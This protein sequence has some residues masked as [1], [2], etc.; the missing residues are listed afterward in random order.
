MQS[1]DGDA[2][3]SLAA[4]KET[5]VRKAIKRMKSH[6]PALTPIIVRI[7][8]TGWPTADQRHSSV[9]LFWLEQRTRGEERRFPA[10]LFGGLAG[11]APE[12]RTATAPPAPRWRGGF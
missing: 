6:P 3:Q 5:S 9:P 4:G 10:I 12:I 1:R 11:K 7:I 8:G 2:G